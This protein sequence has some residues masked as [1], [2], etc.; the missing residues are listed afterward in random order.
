MNMKELIGCCGLDCETC[1]ARLATI[2][3]DDELREATARRWAEAN[4]APIVAEHINCLG[5]R[6]E[7]VKYLYCDRMCP[8]RKCARG[9]GYDTCGDCP[10]VDSCR[11]VGDLFDNVPEA[12]GNL[13]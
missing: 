11:I 5:C 8:I 10:D 3:D 13:K 9:K 6:T 7:G 4:S 2:R 1:D 12:R